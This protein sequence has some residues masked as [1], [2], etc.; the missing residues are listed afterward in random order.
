MQHKETPGAVLSARGAKANDK[1]IR[2][3]AISGRPQAPPIYLIRLRSPRGDSSIRE[4]RQV[5]KILLRRFNWR[6]VSIVEEEARR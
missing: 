1:D 5:L 6:C 4:L 3:N 2:S